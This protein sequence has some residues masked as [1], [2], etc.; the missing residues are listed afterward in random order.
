MVLCVAVAMVFFGCGK[1]DADSQN[2]GQGGL[3]SPSALVYAEPIIS[4]ESDPAPQ[5]L[6]YTV[7]RIRQGD[8]ISELADQFDITTDTLHSVNKIKATKLIQ[9][10]QYLKVPPLSGI[11]YTVHGN[12]ET[13]DSIAKKYEV[14]AEKF[15]EVNHISQTQIL[16]VGATLFVPD[17]ALDWAT[18]QEINGDLFGW[19]L[20]QSWRFT[21]GFGWRRSPFTGARSYH[22]GIDLAVPAG[23]NA[24]AALSGTVVSVGYDSTY[25]NHVIISHGN[26]YQTLYGHFNSVTV[27]QGQYVSTSTVIGKV[28]STG[29]STGPHLHFTVYKN[30]RMI[31]PLS[32]LP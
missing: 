19:P 2:S 15:A 7:Y 31:N 22:G 5:P 11:L 20:K 3:E 17:A 21:S 1:G 14:S 26:G 27:T 29:L 18:R 10:G 12:N 24:Y 25:G 6:S 13:I 30:G 9:P 28:G 23:S 16:Q 4:D 32:V 8:T